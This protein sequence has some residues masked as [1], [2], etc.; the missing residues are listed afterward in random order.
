MVVD[1]LARRRRVE[2]GHGGI[3]K[4]KCLVCF[5]LCTNPNPDPTPNPAIQ[6]KMTLVTGFDV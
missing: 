3:E 2:L 5:S 1:L 6:S 4:E